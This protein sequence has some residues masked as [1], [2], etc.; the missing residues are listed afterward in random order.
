MNL[1]P[2]P[3]SRTTSSDRPAGRTAPPRRLRTASPVAASALIALV[4]IAGTPLRAAGQETAP[5][6][7]EPS[8]P[9]QPTSPS[10]A[11]STAPAPPPCSAPE[12]R[13][14]DFWIGD[15]EVTDP[16]GA[17]QGTNRIEPILG[18]CVLKESWSG[19]GGSEGNSFN[20]YHAPTRRWHQTWVDDHGT[21]LLLDGGLEDGSMV[22]TGTSKARDGG[23]V[24]HRITWTP[25]PDGSVRQHWQTSRDDGATWSDAFDGTYRKTR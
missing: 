21:L 8:Q 12:H 13:Q 22:L 6:P 19:T 9:A 20:L 1:A 14:F 2:V 15:W 10:G 25:R 17:P 16:A 24:S 18:G 4:A 23:T 11:A 3:A 5:P 7:Q